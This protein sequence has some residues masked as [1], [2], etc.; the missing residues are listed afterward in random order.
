MKKNILNEE[1]QSMKYLFD[2]KRGRVISE[3]VTYYKGADG[4]VGMLQGPYAL[5]QGATAITQQEYQNSTQSNPLLSTAQ[6]VSQAATQQ[7]TTTTTTTA[8]PKKVN[9]NIS[10]YVKEAQTLLGVTADGKFGPKSL[11]ALKLKLGTTSTSGTTGTTVS[12]KCPPGQV[13]DETIKGCTLPEVTVTASRNPS[14]TQ[15]VSGATTTAGTQQVSGA[16][17]T[18]QVS[19][20]TTA[21]GTQQAT[22]QQAPSPD[23]F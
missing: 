20:A 23:Q 5:P 10:D 2:Y 14:G 6:Q 16:T 7:S 12:Q 17:G 9:T 21:A 1:L 13:Y 3:Q 8:S 11:E 18:Q 15:Q 4:K 19:G 22:A